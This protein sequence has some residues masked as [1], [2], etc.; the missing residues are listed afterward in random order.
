MKRR[1]EGGTE[2]GE[3]KGGRAVSIDHNFSKRKESRSGFEPRSG[4]SSALPA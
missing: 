3:E 1:G 2:V 4:L